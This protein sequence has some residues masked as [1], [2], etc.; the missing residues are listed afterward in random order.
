MCKMTNAVTTVLSVHTQ[1]LVAVLWLRLASHTLQPATHR[2]TSPASTH[3]PVIQ[4]R[5]WMKFILIPSYWLRNPKLQS[6]KHI[7]NLEVQK[8][9]TT[10]CYFFKKSLKIC[11]YSVKLL[12]KQATGEYILTSISGARDRICPT[13]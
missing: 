10:D 13:H 7:F 9:F 12:G 8:T 4:N 11:L 3:S 2:V 6:C 1:S 5:S